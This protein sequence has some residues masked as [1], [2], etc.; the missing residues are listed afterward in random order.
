MVLVLISTAGGAAAAAA[1]GGGGGG[2]GGGVVVGM[3]VGDGGGGGGSGRQ[4]RS[5][6]P[7]RSHL[8]QNNLTRA[9]FSAWL[10]MSLVPSTK[11]EA[12][13]LFDWQIDWCH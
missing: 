10:H 7:A 12:F 8:S 9:C 5:N 2:G 3:G 6:T 4:R 11:N 1:A 13:N